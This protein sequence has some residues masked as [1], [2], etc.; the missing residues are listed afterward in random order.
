[1]GRVCFVRT[2]T[3]EAQ[4][5]LEESP[6]LNFLV[7]LRGK[8]T[9][10]DL[11]SFKRCTLAWN[12]S[13]DRL[14][15]RWSTAIPTPLAAWRLTLAALSSAKVNPLPA[16]TLMLYL[17]VGQRTTGRRRLIGR[18]ATRLA[19]AIRALRRLVLLAGWLNQ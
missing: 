3:A 5:S 12:A 13:S 10:L 18:G 6:F 17:T 11:Y 9:N 14:V 19:L 16:R 2:W 8:T 7:F 4:A 15:R 1:M